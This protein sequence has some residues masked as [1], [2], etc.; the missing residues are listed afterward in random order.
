MEETIQPQELDTELA[1]D[2]PDLDNDSENDL[3]TEEPL[4]DK[5]EDTQGFVPGEQLAAIS[6]NGSKVEVHF[7]NSDPNQTAQLC[8]WLLQN[9]QAHTGTKSI[10]TGIQ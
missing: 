4:P 8:L 3:H 2:K 6:Y 7:T 9:S 5:K 1:L 10:P